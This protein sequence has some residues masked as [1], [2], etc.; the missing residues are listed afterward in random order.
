M[1]IESVSTVVSIVPLASCQTNTAPDMPQKSEATSCSKHFR[2]QDE[3]PTEAVYPLKKI[4]V[5]KQ[6]PNGHNFSANPNPCFVAAPPTQP[7]DAT[8]NRQGNRFSHNREVNQGAA[9]NHDKPHASHE[10]TAKSATTPQGLSA[11]PKSSS[12]NKNFQ[13]ES[14]SENPQPPALEKRKAP[15]SNVTPTTKKREKAAKINSA[16]KSSATEI[17]SIINKFP[18]CLTPKVRDLLSDLFLDQAL[19]GVSINLPLL[20]KGLE[21]FAIRCAPS[22]STNEEDS[23]PSPTSTSARAIYLSE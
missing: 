12:P 10:S 8:S 2:F 5:V 21:K 16:A 3:T 7:L 14:H 9:S 23:S 20:E 17:N 15:A 18:K 11:A 19:Q 22:D 13:Q 6:E 1:E 4:Q